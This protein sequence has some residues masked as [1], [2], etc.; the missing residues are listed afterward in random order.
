M[1]EHK[2]TMLSFVRKQEKPYELDF[3]FIHI[4]SWATK[5][6]LDL[7]W[8]MAT[9]ASIEGWTLQSRKERKIMDDAVARLCHSI[10]FRVKLW[11]EEKSYFDFFPAQVATL[12]HSLLESS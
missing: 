10:Q 5:E 11:G 6:Q 2:S 7:A 12:D 4:G 8:K 3:L 1:P 9:I